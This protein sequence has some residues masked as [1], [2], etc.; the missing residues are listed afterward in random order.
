MNK[1]FELSKTVL[2]H[3]HECIVET[4]KTFDIFWADFCL[5]INQEITEEKLTYYHNELYKLWER[6]ND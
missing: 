6:N 5:G 1:Y 2:I 4:F 3:C